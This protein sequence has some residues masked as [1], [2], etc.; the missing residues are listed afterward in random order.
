MWGQGSSLE[1]GVGKKWWGRG[2]AAPRLMAHL[3]GRVKSG[4]A[5]GLTPRGM[6]P[7]GKVRFRRQCSLFAVNLSWRQMKQTS[8]Y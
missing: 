1:K 5:V 4:G 7:A 2:V 3:E 6:G 8:I